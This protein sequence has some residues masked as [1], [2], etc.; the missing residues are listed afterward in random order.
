MKTPS[1]YLKLY[2]PSYKDV[3]IISVIK[4]IQ[5][6]AYNQCLADLIEDNRVLDK[7]ETIKKFKK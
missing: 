5:N 3:T 4:I 6:E 1:D 7:K 2:F